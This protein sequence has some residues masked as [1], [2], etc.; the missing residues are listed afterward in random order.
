MKYEHVVAYVASAAW[1]ILPS[2][3]TE[4]LSVLAFR[5][6]GHTFTAAEIQARVGERSPGASRSASRGIAIVPIRG[7]I[8]HRMG[9]LD[10]SSGGT[11]YER[12]ATMLHQVLADESVGTIVLDCD[13]PGGTV[14]GVSELAAEIF[15]ARRVKRIVAVANSVCASAGFWL[16]SQAHEVVA[17]PSALVGSIGVFTVHASLEAALAKE[18]VKM[19]LVKFGEFKVENNP[20]EDLTKAGLTQLQ[21]HVN[22]SGEQFVADVARGRGTTPAF[23]RSHYGDGRVFSAKDAQTAGLVDRIATLDDVLAQTAA[24]PDARPR[25]ITDERVRAQMS[26]HKLEVDLLTLQI[27]AVASGSLTGGAR[28]Q[29]DELKLQLDIACL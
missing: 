7:V 26:Q 15:A 19:T 20:F 14:A 18:G 16:A 11:S 23:V 28:Q 4:I 24:A 12:I 8:A 5:A 21:R 2:K 1:A 3:L 6:A 10:D 29:Y 22:Q 27:Q 9:S 17:I 25:A 13:T